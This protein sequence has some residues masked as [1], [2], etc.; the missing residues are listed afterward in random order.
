MFLGFNFYPQS[1]RYL[2]LE[3]FEAMA[4]ELPPLPKI[5]VLV[6]PPAG[7]FGLAPAGR[8]RHLSNPLPD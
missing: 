8:F 6:E 1:P 5:A 3:K 4:G 7:E 2:P